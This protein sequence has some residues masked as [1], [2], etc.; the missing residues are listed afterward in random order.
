MMIIK[1]HL[2]WESILQCG[3]RVDAAVLVVLEILWDSGYEK[4]KSSLNGK[5]RRR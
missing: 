2:I 5:I 1:K 4:H 3:R